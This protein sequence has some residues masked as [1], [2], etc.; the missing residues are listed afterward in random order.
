MTTN[1]TTTLTAAG[2]LAARR[3][4]QNPASPA[5]L[6]VRLDRRFVVTPTI[7][8]L[9]DIAVRA[10]QEPDQRDI[11]TTPPRTG[12]SRLLA[13]WT[14]V[15]ALA[16]NPDLQIVLVSYSDELAQAHSR[17]ARQLIN[18]HS[19]ALG[20]RLSP[21][22]T[23]VGRWRVDGRAGGLLATGINSGVTG[24]G[25]D[26]LILDDVVKDAAE[27]D[28]AAHRRRVVNEYRSTLATRVHP[29]GSVLLVM[30][31]WHE[32]DLAGELLA[33]EPDVWTHTNVPAVATA[34]V[35]DALAR[36]P[37][38][39]MTSALGFTA[40]HYA[41]NRRTSGERAW[42]ALY[43]GVP[44]APAGG[45]VKREWLD[46]WRLPAAPLAP[47][48]TV[49]GVDPSDSGSGDSCGLIAA[50][51]TTDGVVAVI[52]DKSEPMTSDQWAR[53]AVQLAADVGA[54]EI[55][56]EGFAARETYVRVVTEAL[57][58]AKLGRPVKVSSWPPKGS[59][60]GGGD[61]MARSAALLQGL[62]VGTARIAGHL[63]NLEQHAV[64]W[65]AG[66]HQPDSLAA[67]VVA[68]DVLVHAA[69]AQV[70]IATPL[71]ATLARTGRPSIPGSGG[72]Q[73]LPMHNSLARSV[74]RR[75]S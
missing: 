15:W 24:F 11:V 64:S 56:V 65:Q 63:P 52:A 72:G 14:V 39:A 58:R 42:A 8:L 3:T 40:E 74:A 33:A 60:R 48:K 68:H 61:A 53:E 70:T 13:I 75:T 32:L 51:I 18:E 73:V 47:I 36:E 71:G 27:A 25:A 7:R 31:R 28:S 1:T 22:K 46:T 62:E 12:K 4:R 50:S 19:E 35:P 69:G 10:V 21:D 6:A 23:A 59:G 29:G 45:L 44:T 41:A 16:N 66:Q 67:V 5:E 49:V 38:A 37:G 20:F 26:L 30:T 54:S 34:G 9:S 2:A 57:K 43:L 55:A 17:E